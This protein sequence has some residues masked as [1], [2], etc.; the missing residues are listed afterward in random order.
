M[1]PKEETIAYRNRKGGLSL[2]TMV[3]CGASGRI[4]YAK[5][6]SQGSHHDS[7]V[8]TT[9]DLK[10]HLDTHG[11]PFEDAVI[12]ADSA[13][14]TMLPYM[15]TPFRDGTRNRRERRYNLRFNRARVIIENVFGWTK[16]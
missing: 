9:S 1:P 8:F 5:S 16:V 15:A 13:Y 3:L 10:P 6:T 7:H 12:I 11:T 14:P 4:Y 2:N